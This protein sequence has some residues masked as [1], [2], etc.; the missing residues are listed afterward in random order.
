[1]CPMPDQT[2]RER[3]LD[4]AWAEADERGIDQLTLAAVGARAGVSRQAVYLHFG[5]RATLLVEMTARFDRTSGFRRRLAGTREGAPV[6]GFHGLLEVWFDYLPTILRVGVALEAA[7]LTGGEGSDAYRSRMD[8]WWA[9]IRIA[10]QRLDDAGQV[11]PGVGRRCGYRLGVGQCPPHDVPPPRRGA[12]LVR[13]RRYGT[14]HSLTDPRIA[15][16]EQGLDE[17]ARRR[18]TPTPATAPTRPMADAAL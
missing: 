5:N 13:H 7:H 14:H 6:E 4:A 12:R 16:P 8:D 15:S 9:G 18:P 10:V 2:T 1:M 3:L 11:G 17:R